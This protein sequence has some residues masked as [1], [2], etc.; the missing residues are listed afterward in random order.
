MPRSL[1]RPAVALL[2][3]A[4]ASSPQ[5][6]PPTPAPAPSPAAAPAPAPAPAPAAASAAGIYDFTTSVQGTAVSG[7]VTVTMANGRAG[8][9]IATSAT[10]EIPIKAVTVEGPKVTVTADSPDGEAV[11][12]FTMNGQDFSGTWWFG[13]QSGSLTGRK[14]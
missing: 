10:P 1:V 7:V 12:E 11:L 13:G 9:T 8:G 3:A 6:A 5:A 2:L 14:R 4:C